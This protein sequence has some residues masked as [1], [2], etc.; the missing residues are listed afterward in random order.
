[1]PAK[2]RARARGSGSHL[3]DEAF[4][5]VWLP[6][7][8]EPVVAGVAE[9]SR[10]LL[11]FSYGDSYLER[12][13]A[14]PLYLPEL[15][16]TDEAIPPGRGLRV[17]GCLRDAAPDAWGQ[18]IIHAR[19]AAAGHDFGDDL[20]TFM[21]ESGSDRIGRLDFQT[22]P[23]QYVPRGAPADLGELLDAAVRF[24]E[25]EAFTEALA[26][27]LLHGTSIGGARPKAL[28]VDRQAGPDG[29]V[30]ERQMVAKFS[31]SSD[32]YPVV[33]A[34]AVAMNL[35]RRVGL[36]VASS[37]LVVRAG[38]D[39]LL[40]DRF[41]RPG[42]VGSV[43]GT[44]GERRIIVSALTILELPEEHGRHATYPALADAIRKR[45]TQPKATLRELFGRLVFSVLVA[46]TDDHAR[47]HAAFWDGVALTLTPAYDISPQMR[48]GQAAAQ[49]MSITRDGARASKLAVVR[50]AAEDVFNL[51]PTQA[52][53][54]IDAQVETIREQW[55]EAAEECQLTGADRQLLW[56]R[57]ILN[58]GVFHDE[59]PEF[60]TYSH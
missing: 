7:T 6:G 26:R 1:M 52:Q 51:K 58:P 30:F 35:A 53:E 21:L 36:E 38:R 29:A 13:E 2:S 8:T 43:P 9:R 18:Q 28:L 59:D 54:I 56:E 11:V 37:E 39:V 46:N 49:A 12:P 15:P 40:V 17:A 31:L 41:D 48:P 23:A 3:P 34:E 50:R 47:N 42:T 25:G 24:A 16:L 45:F 22:S 4:V 19:L 33:K 32:P 14:I 10:D 44:P 27:A 55:T 5:W 20:L 60:D 57:L